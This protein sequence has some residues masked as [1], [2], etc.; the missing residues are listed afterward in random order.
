MHVKNTH[1]LKIFIN[2]IYSVEEISFNSVLQKKKNLI[3]ILFIYLFMDPKFQ[4]F[5]NLLFE[6]LPIQ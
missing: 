3:S 5:N 6:L 2:F 4:I 1:A